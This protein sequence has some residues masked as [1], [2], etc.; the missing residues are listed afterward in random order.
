MALADRAFGADG[1]GHVLVGFA[2]IGDPQSRARNS[3][4]VLGTPNTN[5]VY[6]TKPVSISTYPPWPRLAWV[7]V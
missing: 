7:G 2:P 3:K 6:R 4:N 5:Y 1:K